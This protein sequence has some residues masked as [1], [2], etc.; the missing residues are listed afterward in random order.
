MQ[1]R[2]ITGRCQRVKVGDHVVALH[3]GIEQQDQVQQ[4]LLQIEILRGK[5]FATEDDHRPAEPIDAALVQATDARHFRQ[6]FGA[7][8]MQ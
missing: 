5:P 8:P 3:D 7:R 6:I 1:R 4:R 2:I